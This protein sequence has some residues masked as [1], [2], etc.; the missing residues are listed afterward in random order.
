M[1]HQ[2]LHTFHYFPSP[3]P[4]GTSF[5]IATFPTCFLFELNFDLVFLRLIFP[6]VNVPCPFGAVH[7]CWYRLI[8]C[9]FCVFC[10]FKPHC[11]FQVVGG[12]LSLSSFNWI[13]L[14]IPLSYVP[15]KPFNCTTP[16]SM[17]VFTSYG[18]NQCSLSFPGC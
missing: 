8:S 10:F 4:F 5:S 12:R 6:S 18:P 14:I 13:P 17:T 9:F 3:S 15:P 7:L 16:P 1:N 2:F 11:G